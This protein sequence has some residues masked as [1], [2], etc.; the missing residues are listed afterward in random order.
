[1]K[2]CQVELTILIWGSKGGEICQNSNLVQNLAREHNPIKEL[3]QRG[4]DGGYE[5][6][7]RCKA[8]GSPVAN[9]YA[10]SNNITS[11]QENSN[12]DVHSALTVS[13]NQ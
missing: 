2:L 8:S 1:M 5:I 3:S 9:R 4:F 6:M 7:S 10:Q 12:N 11:E 13:N